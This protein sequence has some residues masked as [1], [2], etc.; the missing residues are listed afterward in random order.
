MAS[1]NFT[2]TNGTHL[3]DHTASMTWTNT[4]GTNPDDYTIQSNQVYGAAWKAA[5]SFAST[6]TVDSS[7]ITWL[8]NQTYTHGSKPCVRMPSNNIGYAAYFSDSSGGNWTEVTITK[9]GSY[10]G[11]YT[12][13]S[14]AQSDN[15]TIKITASGSSPVTLEVFVDGVSLGTKSDSSSP[16][17]S[18]YSGFSV[19]TASR[20][21]G[22]LM[23]DWTDGAASGASST[24]SSTPF[25]KPFRQALGRGGL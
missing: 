2:D 9:N 12:S 23:D 20:A 24:P 7:Q 25:L 21:A 17:A 1:D 19:A 15:H 5:V 10:F 14:Y 4:T 18:G 6:S 16:L 11:S 22:A 13:L 3:L 8:G